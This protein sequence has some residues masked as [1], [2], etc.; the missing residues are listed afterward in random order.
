MRVDELPFVVRS[1]WRVLYESSEEDTREPFDSMV[2]SEILE[3]EQ[4]GLLACQSPPPPPPPSVPLAVLA[5]T[6]ALWPC[7]LCAL[8]LESWPSHIEAGLCRRQS[9]VEIDHRVQHATFPNCGSLLVLTSIRVNSCCELLVSHRHVKRLVTSSSRSQP[10][11]TNAGR[12]DGCFAPAEQWF[13]LDEHQQ[14]P[15]I[16]SQQCQH[17]L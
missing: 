8:E 17:H 5:L 9:Q 11:W 6:L 14:Q 2:R 12:D 7:P 15:T 16:A 10:R 1:R 4:L 3:V 13:P